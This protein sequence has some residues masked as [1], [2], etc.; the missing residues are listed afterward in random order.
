MLTSLTLG[1]CLTRFNVLAAPVAAT[2]FAAGAAIYD[3]VCD[4]SF[5]HSV[6]MG[7]VTGLVVPVGYLIGQLLRSSRQ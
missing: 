4:S 2:V 1:L 6:L 3:M 5:A 7:V